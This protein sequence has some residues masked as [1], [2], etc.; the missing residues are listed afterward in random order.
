MNPNGASAEALTGVVDNPRPA[1]TKPARAMRAKRVPKDERTV[2][3]TVFAPPAARPGDPI[4]VQVFVHLPIQDVEARAL[5]TEFDTETAV[6]RSL[7]ATVVAV[8]AVAWSALAVVQ[9]A[10][11]HATAQVPWAVLFFG[12]AQAAGVCALLAVLRAVASR[13]E[14]AKNR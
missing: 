3:C 13:R 8:A 11:V 6:Q 10:D 14:D 2:D 4:L 7:R 12:S 1:V 9:G 5:A